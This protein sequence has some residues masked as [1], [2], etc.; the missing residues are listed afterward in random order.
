VSDDSNAGDSWPLSWAETPDSW[1]HPVTRPAPR[2]PRPYT[3]RSPAS[4]G[5]VAPSTGGTARPTRSDRHAQRRRWRRALLR[6][7]A[8]VAATFTALLATAAGG[9]AA[10]AYQKY[11]G[12]ITRVSVLQTHDANIRNAALQQN[13]E[14]F[15]VIGSDS[16]AGLSRSFGQIDG[17]RSDTAMIVHLSKDRHKATIISVP[18]DSWVTIPKCRAADGHTEAEHQDMFNSA[19]TVGGPSCT[20]ATV[21]RLTGIEINHYVEINF[22]G[23]E[24]MVSALGRVTVCSPAAVD[25]RGSGLILHVGS[26]KL[27]GSQALAY[28]RARETLGD[29]SDLGRIKRQQ[30]FLG[31]VLRQAM[32]GALLSNPSR[33]TSFLDAATKAITVDKKTTF[34]DLH[35]LAASLQGLDPKRVTFYTAPIAD[36]NYSPPGTSMTGRVLLDAVAGR[37]LYDSVIKDVPLAAA[38]PKSTS[39][40][41]S[42]HAT[43]ANSTPTRSTIST[44]PTPKANLNAAQ[45]S[46]SL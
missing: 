26:N 36:P 13:A 8:I 25:D 44:S 14:N 11:N 24:S 34:G 15:L 30:M 28:V 32:N 23:F 40:S 5:D 12:Q 17:A 10:Y 46:C 31:D 22:S 29:G 33:L 1:S 9:L 35:A 21:Q 7:T 20:I 37:R 4:A 3:P 18:R 41:S 27:D 2:R 38:A 19:F 39:G 16:R 45:Q 42:S 6:R 43:P